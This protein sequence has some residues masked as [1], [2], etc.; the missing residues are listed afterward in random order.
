[1]R[2]PV[3]PSAPDLPGDAVDVRFA[4]DG[5]GFA[6]LGECRKTGCRQRVAVL[7]KGGDAWRLRQS[8]LPDTTGNDGIAA[9]LMVLGP[10]RALLTEGR[11]PPPERT[12]FTS[13]GGRS[14]RQGSSRPPGTT[15]VVPEGGALVEG[16]L[17][18]DREG[19]GCER[20]PLL[21]VLP[22]TG[23]FRTL[24]TQPPLKGVI[25]P[26]G[27]SAANWL[28]VFGRDPRSGQPALAVSEDR[29]RSWRT[30]RLP[31]AQGEGGAARVVAA[32]KVLYAARPG[33]LPDETDVKNGLLSL[34]RSTDGG[35][36]WEQVFVHRKGV[37]PRSILGVP[38]AGADG[39]LTI[40]SEDGVWRS[41]DGGRS[42][43]RRAGSG[44]MSGW[45]TTTALFYLWGDSF[46]AGNWRLSADGVRWASF[47][48]GGG[49]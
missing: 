20:S 27:E 26:A 23:Q 3:I 29:G 39:S 5:S 40:H 10:G 18:V 4:R 36:T 47:D 2:S 42:F 46:G 11:W 12:W 49:T 48:L 14:W 7:D 1:M 35:H 38:V 16:C 44:G 34:H 19:N 25:S 6:L 15:A 13:D 45:V 17:R 9:E 32:G 8:P 30:S 22:A 21:A 43:A 37:E 28:F 31:G 33:P 24:A 41:T